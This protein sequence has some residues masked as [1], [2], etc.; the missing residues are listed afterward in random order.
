MLPQPGP[1]QLRAHCS[2]LLRDD[3]AFA[4]QH[5]RRNAADIVASRQFRLCF[6]VYFQKP[7]L[8][9]EFGGDVLIDRRHCLAWPTPLRPEI[10]DDW[11]VVSLDVGHDALRRSGMRAAGEQRLVTMAA[12][13]PAGILL[14]GNTIYSLAVRTDDV[15]DL[16]AHSWRFQR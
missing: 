8:G 4:E 7:K 1:E 13:C 10:D 12:L 11:D 14:A 6:G 9:F 2:G 5:Q 16:F 15:S 3:I